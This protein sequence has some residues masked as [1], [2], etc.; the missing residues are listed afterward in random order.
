[1]TEQNAPLVLSPGWENELNDYWVTTDGKPN[2]DTVYS[3][4]LSYCIDKQGKLK[5][6]W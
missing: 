4:I 1:M 2:L 3:I 6:L 5:T